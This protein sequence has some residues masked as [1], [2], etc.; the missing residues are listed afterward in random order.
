MKEKAGVMKSPNIYMQYVRSS[1][2][3]ILIPV[4]GVSPK[5]VVEMDNASIYHIH[6]VV[7]T[8]RSVGALVKFL[9][10]YSTD[11][12]SVEEVFASKARSDQ[13]TWLSR[14]RSIHV[15]Y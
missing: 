4:D 7:A 13:T 11:L 2:L 14:L 15:C 8:I 5:S 12:N 1:L 3:P 10:P 9:P 6:E